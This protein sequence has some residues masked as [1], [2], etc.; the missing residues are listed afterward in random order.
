MFPN[1]PQCHQHEL[2]PRF[3]SVTEENAIRFGP[4]S[5]RENATPSRWVERLRPERPRIDRRRALR[6]PRNG[7]LSVRRK[8]IAFRSLPQPI[9]L[10]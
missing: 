5:L 2:L 9:E 1:V 8:S 4:G 6:T 3:R 7:G 10:T